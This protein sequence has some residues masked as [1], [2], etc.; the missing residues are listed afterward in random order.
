VNGAQDYWDGEESVPAE[1][2]QGS[3]TAPERHVTVVEDDVTLPPVLFGS[4]ETATAVAEDN[5]SDVSV[6]PVPA[7]D[8]LIV[9]SDD[10]VESIELYSLSGALIQQLNINDYSARIE[11]ANIAS[12]LYLLK[13]KVNSIFSLQK[14]T[15]QH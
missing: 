4:C 7:D 10:I 13:L 8:F 2:N 9:S 5:A 14:I 15:I 3:D 1:C 11:T 12:G 6:Y